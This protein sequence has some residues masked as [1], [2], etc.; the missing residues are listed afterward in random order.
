V[1]EPD[2]PVGRAQPPG[3]AHDAPGVAFYCVSDERYFLGAV[4]MVNSL[5]LAGHTEP[6]YLLDVGLTGEQRAL[7]GPHVELVAGDSDL[8][9]W[10]LKTVAP[11]RHPAEVMVLIDADIVVLRSLHELLGRA[12]EGSCVAFRTDYERHYASWG[13]MLRLGNVRRQPYVCTGLIAVDRATGE[14]LL[15]LVD[16]RKELVAEIA[17]SDTDPKRREAFFALDQDLINAILG[18]SFDRARAVALDYR[19]APVPPFADLQ[20]RGGERRCVYPDGLEP[21]LLHQHGPKP[22]LSGVSNSVYTELLGRFL[23]DDDVPIRLGPESIPARLRT[24]PL[25]ALARARLE[26]RDRLPRF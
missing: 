6:I 12:R 20:V 7:I 17:F 19:L 8:P 5:R 26:L 11:L 24:G 22:W 13:A 16:E 14:Q 1:P 2:G 9:A 25:G 18:S 10:L 23:T 15:R 4:G 3:V 21:Y